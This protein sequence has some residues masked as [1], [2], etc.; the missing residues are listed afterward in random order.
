MIYWAR[1][2]AESVK[3]F[4]NVVYHVCRSTLMEIPR[5]SAFTINVG[6]RVN[7][8]LLLPVVYSL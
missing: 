4:L 8:V 2:E 6:K 1:L 5:A 3:S 7:P